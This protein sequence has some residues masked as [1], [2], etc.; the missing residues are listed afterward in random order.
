HYFSNSEKSKEFENMR[1]S[2][3]RDY[4][5]LF[6]RMALLGFCVFNRHALRTALQEGA[7]L[8]IFLNAAEGQTDPPMTSLRES[9]LAA[10]L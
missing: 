6:A 5:E 7:S 8:L 9:R 10:L 3:A 1:I 4:A 2:L